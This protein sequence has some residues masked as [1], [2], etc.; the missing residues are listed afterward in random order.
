MAKCVNCTMLNQRM[1]VARHENPYTLA[2]FDALRKRA[3][4][5]PGSQLNRRCPEHHPDGTATC[6]LTKEARL[7]VF[8]GEKVII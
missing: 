7:G 2:T 4:H 5:T 3:R 1:E 8:D 6:T